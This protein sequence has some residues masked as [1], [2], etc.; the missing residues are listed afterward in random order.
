MGELTIEDLKKELERMELIIEFLC[1]SLGP[2]AGDIMD[3]AESYATDNMSKEHD[4]YL[5]SCGCE[6]DEEDDDE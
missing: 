1:G 6:E 5:C 3:M 4:S 2:A